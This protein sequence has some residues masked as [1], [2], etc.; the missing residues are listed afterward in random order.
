MESWKSSFGTLSIQSRRFLEALSAFYLCISRVSQCLYVNPSDTH[1]RLAIAVER[2]TS[3]RE[4]GNYQTSAWL[5]I[6]IHW[7]FPPSLWEG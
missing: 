2:W 6:I 3:W 1:V 5:L 7:S 4:A